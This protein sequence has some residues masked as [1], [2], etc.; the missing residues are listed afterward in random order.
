[1][2]RFAEL[3][4]DVWLWSEWLRRGNKP[5]T[6]I[7]ILQERATAIIAPQCKFLILLTNYKRPTLIHFYNLRK[8]P[9][10]KRLI[11]SHR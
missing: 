9:F 11:I 2:I 1:M 8:E 10:K 7:D 6:G 3:Y 4:S 5:D